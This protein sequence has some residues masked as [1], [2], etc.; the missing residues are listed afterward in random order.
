MRFWTIGAAALIAAIAAGSASAAKL[1]TLYSFCRKADCTDGT[2]PHGIAMDAAGNLF[3][4]TFTGQM[5]GG[6]VVYE[7]R[8][9]TN[10]RK[11]RQNV[12][13]SFCNEK[14]CRNYAPFSAFT[15]D[16]AGNLFGITEDGPIDGTV[17]ELVPDKSPDG[18]NY[19]QIY[20]LCSLQNCA[21]G[22]HGDGAMAI[23]TA[24]N[25]YGV[26]YQGGAHGK[27][28]VFELSPPISG[29]GKWTEKVLY[30]FCSKANCSDG[31]EPVD[32]LTYAGAAKGLPYDGT[33]PLYGTTQRGGYDYGVVFS[34]TPSESGSWQEELLHVFCPK[35]NPQGG[36]CPDGGTP[37]YMGP[38]AIDP[39]GNIIGANHWGYIYKLSPAANHWRETILYDLCKIVDC[40]VSLEI[41]NPIIDASGNLYG[42]ANNIAYRLT[43]NGDQVTVLYEFCT[44]ENCPNGSVA[45]SALIMDAGGKLYGTTEGGGAYSNGTVF[46][47]SP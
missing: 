32:G 13:H 3:G 18:W 40:S 45:S 23:D 28:V 6:S 21:D 47:I 9:P 11:W 1:S 16:T 29:S 24:G 43:P 38:L 35:T 37:S 2:G 30:D 33:S 14:S 20:K 27:G 25:V 7:L 8:A 5:L 12:L 15:P 34:L 17:F 41:S 44:G 19:Q 22:E 26:A 39:S 42:T 36:S 31:D 4:T 10:G 46:K